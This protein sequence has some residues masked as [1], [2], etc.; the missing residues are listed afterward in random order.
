MNQRWKAV[1]AA[2]ALKAGFARMK[3]TVIELRTAKHVG[4]RSHS[5]AAG[6]QFPLAFATAGR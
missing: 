1:A 3:D 6:S 2:T 5:P 4:L